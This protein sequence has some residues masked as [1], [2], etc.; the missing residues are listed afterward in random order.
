MLLPEF[1]E[2][3]M[4]PTTPIANRLLAALTPE[5]LDILRAQLEPVPLPHKTDAL[6]PRVRR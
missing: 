5:D 4:P 2:E 3:H 6:A 1:S